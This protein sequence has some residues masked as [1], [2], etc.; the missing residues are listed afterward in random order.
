MDVTGD[1]TTT[2]L[3]NGSWSSGLIPSIVYRK[4]AAVVALLSEVIG[5]NTMRRVFRDYIREN[6]WKAANTSTFLR[7]LD[8]DV[9]VSTLKLLKA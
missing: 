5:A 8:N 2:A 9:K 4:G 7:I 3:I 6:Q 1:V